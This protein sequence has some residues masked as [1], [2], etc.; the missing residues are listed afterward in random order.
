MGQYLAKR[1][2]LLIPTFLLV[3]IICFTIIRVIPG[4]AAVMMMADQGYGNGDVQQLRESLGLNQPLYRQYGQ[5]ISGV[6]RGDLGSSL[7]SGQPILDT[8]LHKRLPVTLELGVMA[9]LFSLLIAVPIGITSATRQNSVMDYL[10]RTFA[11]GGLS[12]PYFFLGTLAVLISSMYLGWLPS[13]TFVPFFTNPAENLLQFLMPGMIL[14][15]SLA[16]RIMRM[17]RSAMLDV[18]RQDYIRTAAAKGLPNRLVV[19]RHALRNAL[20]PV[21][22]VIGL[23]VPYLIGGTVIMEQIFNLPGMGRLLFEGATKRDYPVVQGVTLVFALIVM[24]ANLLTDIS[25]SLI[26]PRIRHK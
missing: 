18:M 13:V 21:V 7:W 16:A 4:D 24:L 10:G 25:Y 6:V 5:Y 22:T 11:I 15:L 3:T 26:D 14:G 8:M 9:M 17:L 2:L 20:V 23:Q 19:T 1:L 12:V